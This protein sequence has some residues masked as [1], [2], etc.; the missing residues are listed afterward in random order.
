[1]VKMIPVNEDGIPVFKRLDPSWN[2]TGSFCKDKYRFFFN[3]S[4]D[5]L[6]S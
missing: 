1:M 4:M 3:R 5:E 2:V 6:F